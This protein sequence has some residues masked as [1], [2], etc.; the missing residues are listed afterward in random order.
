MPGLSKV[1]V[2][3]PDARARR[4]VQLGFEREGVPTAAVEVEAE[5]EAE[6][7]VP[8]DD[9]GLVLVGGTDGH[10]VERIRRARG[11]LDGRGIDAPVVFAGR[12]VDPRD[13]SA[14]GADEVVRHPAYLRD[15]VTIGRMLCGQPAGHRDHVVGNLIELTG[16]FTLVRA[17]SALGRS[18]TLT[19]VRGLRRGEVRFYCGEVTSAHVGMIHGQAA[20]HQ[21]LLWTDARFDFRH[22]DVVRRQQIPMS[23]DELFA[24]AERFLESVRDSSGGLSPAMVLEQDLPRVQSLAKQIPTEVYGV[25]RIFDGHRTVAD[26][27]EDSPYRVFETLRV[28]Q[29]AVE[30]GLIRIVAKPPPRPGWRTILGI[31]DWLVGGEPRDAIAVDDARPA[32]IRDARGAPAPPGPGGGKT[33]RKRRKKKRRTDTPPAVPLRAALRREID[34]GALVP[35]IVGAEVGPLAGVV[36]ASH[37]SGEIV[38]TAARPRSS[39]DPDDAAAR[40]ERAR[41]AEPTIVFDEA[42]V[43]TRDSDSHLAELA[44]AQPA[45]AEPAAAESAAAQPAAAE[46]VTAVPAT[47][48]FATAE[49]ATA[50]T[51]PATAEPAVAELAT[52]EPATAVPATAELA[53]AEPA[54]A[55][56]AEPAAAQLAT[57]E[58]ATAE[59]AAAQLAA[60]QL[61]AAEPVARTDADRIAAERAEAE[62]RADAIRAVAATVS[63]SSEP[64]RVIEDL[65]LD[66]TKPER[67]RGAA[68]AALAPEPAIVAAPAAEPVSRDAAVVEDSA[69]AA[70]D[71]V[72]APLAAVSPPAAE[73]AR[74]PA[75][76]AALDASLVPAASAAPALADPTPIAVVDEPSDGVVRHHIATAETAPVKRRPIPH[77][78]RDDDRPADAT[79]EITTPHQRPPVV[80]R[81]SEPTIQVP[82][83]AAI[84]AELGDVPT[85]QP[86]PPARGA[87]APARPTT[88]GRD[89]TPFNAVE[90]AFFQEGHDKA[91]AGRSDSES[92]DDLD[93]GYRPLGFWERLTGRGKPERRSKP[94]KPDKPGR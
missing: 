64:A 83:L 79:G 24:D 8:G 68:R 7:D 27:L 81:Y 51:E 82:D 60:A 33:A 45:A 19:L 67:P 31:E 65:P 92:F 10:G 77:D 84:Q 13:A 38:T 78:P 74:E 62:A 15:V 73:P 41:A 2:L 87:A 48:E 59:P 52:A 53:T 21:L 42:A 1:I 57:A 25:L 23:R 5:A 63:V 30:A 46:P 16:V 17:L 75:H 35:R 14:A 93:E 70:S 56:T 12:C 18:A 44:A 4:Q 88:G 32:T 49:P 54:T 89:S 94:D 58:P 6:I 76:D 40:T 11:W 29:R 43:L 61:A 90:E 22:E 80:I 85:V 39:S 91:P 20:L 3:D 34:W 86:A 71:A 47:A 72:T 66:D 69:V 9:A 28:A 26:V 37:V 36:P 50:A 55:G